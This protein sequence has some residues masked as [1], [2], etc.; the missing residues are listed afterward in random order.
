MLTQGPE[1]WPLHSMVAVFQ[2]GHS[3]KNVSRDLSSFLYVFLRSFRM[4]WPLNPNY[5]YSVNGETTFLFVIV[6]YLFF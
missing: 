3:R 1:P 5:R 4:P 6:F 2:E